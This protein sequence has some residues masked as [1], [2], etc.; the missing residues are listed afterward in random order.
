MSRILSDSIAQP[1]TVALVLSAFGLAAA[2]LSA[3]GVYGVLSFSVRSR[4]REI[5]VRRALGAQASTI[6]RQVATESLKL[7]AV[8]IPVAL[9]IGA[10]GARFI[11]GI[12]FQTELL[13]PVVGVAVLAFV[14]SVALLA[15]HVPAKRA[16]SVDPATA[17]KGE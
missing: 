10:A 7:I 4:S 14:S 12:L 16:A 17:L 15:S 6:R 8:S 13:D 1:R 2:L 5:S 11:D 9:I 3:L